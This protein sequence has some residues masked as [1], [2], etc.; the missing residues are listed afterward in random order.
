V[1]ATRR[2][3]VDDGAREGS[4]GYRMKQM[5]LDHYISQVHLKKFYSPA[6]HD[7]LYAI[8]KRD[9]K[10]FSAHSRD[11]CRTVDG[12]TNAY[13]KEARVI[14]G[15]LK[16]IEPKYDTALEKLVR[17]AIDYEC[18]YVIAG[19]VAY[20]ICCSPAGMRIKSGHLKC[21]VEAEANILQAQ[22]LLPT[23]PQELGGADLVELLRTGAVRVEVDR[24][25]PQAMGISSILRQ[26]AIFGNFKWEILI[27][28]LHDSA[29]F[30][31][32]FPIAVEE[33]KDWRVVNR[34]VPL[35][36]NLAIRIRPDLAVDTK[37]PNFS[38]AGFDWRTKNIGRKEVAQIN[39]L[40][41]R[42]AEETIFSRDDWAWIQKFV[43]RNRNYRIEPR[44]SKLPKGNGFLLVSS[45]RIAQ[46]SSV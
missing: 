9:L 35:A 8:R 4:C 20:I 15:F 26:T 36:P 39:Q 28:D 37:R 40:I 31:S 27:N 44:T 19:F 41:V 18:V 33:T 32:D 17:G 11:V 10:S 29:F 30:T 16:T 12:S 38:F 2:D 22:G 42:S 6:L 34:I 5:P 7:R 21:V 13:L 25:F 45:E 1:A 24:K 3:S 14:E 23:P 46:M 43:A